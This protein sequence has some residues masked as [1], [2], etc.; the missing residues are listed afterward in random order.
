ME[1]DKIY[2]EDCLEGMKRLDDHSIDCVI[3]DPP[4]G[5]LNKRSAGARLDTPI[6]FEPMWEQINRVKKPADPVLIF[7]QGKFTARLVMSNMKSWRYNLVW[8]KVRP[9]G[10]LNAR[11]MPLRVHE[12]ICVFYDKLPTY[13]PQKTKGTPN[14]SRGRNA[15]IRNNH[16]CYGKVNESEQVFTD[17][18]FPT[19]VISI[20]TTKT[21][22]KHPTQ[23]PLALMRY[24]VRQYSNPGDVILDFCFGSGSTIVAAMQEHRHYVGFELDKEYYDIA[25]KRIE[26]QNNKEV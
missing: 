5:V 24:L 16:R 9:V 6:A 13:N 22:N 17:E 3:I 20:P 11:R 7:G 21:G 10:F 23:K 19:S 8:N 4:Y 1:L 18:K 25:L 12:D 2:N 14:H 15:G 26:E